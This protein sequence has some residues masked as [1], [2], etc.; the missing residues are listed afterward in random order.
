[1]ATAFNP[2][3]AAFKPIASKGLFSSMG[4]Q[5]FEQWKSGATPDSA[6]PSI[7]PQQVDDSVINAVNKVTSQDSP[8]M[9]AARTEGLKTAN[10]RGLLNSSIAA[11]TSQDAMM[12]YAVPIGSQDASQN[13][14]RN[15]NAR[16][17]VIFSANCSPANWRPGAS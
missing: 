1:M 16:G 10:A 9:Q 3:T 8:L 17:S 13:F 15:Q 5:T 2:N 12:R 7:A 11:G 14:Q 4:G 6:M